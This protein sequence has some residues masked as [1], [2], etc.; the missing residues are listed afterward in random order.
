MYNFIKKKYNFL[1]YIVKVGYWKYLCLIVL[2][3]LLYVGSF[4]LYVV[5]G[6]RVC[7]YLGNFN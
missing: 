3:G 5:F 1:F 2:I 4:F 6:C 7:F